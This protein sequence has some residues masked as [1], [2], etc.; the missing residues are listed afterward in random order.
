ML[1]IVADDA[2]PFLRGAFEDYAR[3]EYLPWERIVREKVKDADALII[4]TRTICN[5]GLLEGSSVRFIATATIGYDHI[6]TGYCDEAG[7]HRSS[8]PGCNAGSVMQYMASAIIALCDHTRRLPCEM[9]LGIV[10]VGHVGS[11]VEKLATALGM[12]VLKC[13][14]PRARQEGAGHYLS[15][16]DLL[17][18][19]DIVTLHVPLTMGGADPTC[20]MINEVS[21]KAMKRGAWLIN[22]AR[23]GVAETASLKKAL[24]NGHL[25][26]VILDVWEEEPRID[27]ELLSS[28]LI[29]TP[30]IA[31]YSLDGKA[32]G[33]IMAVRSVAGYFDLPLG[34]WTPRE[35]PADP[36]ELEL[37]PAG[38]TDFT[39]TREAILSVYDIFRDDDRL[40][41]NP[42]MFE[43]QRIHYPLRRDFRA[44][45]IR[46]VQGYHNVYAILKEL[47]FRILPEKTRLP[48]G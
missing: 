8:A 15:F 37:N 38:K 39:A 43:Q 11:R 45:V 19:S 21:I 13:D 47:G 23:G 36:P 6:D 20:H 34:N 4:R 1:R 29:G 46:Q 30:H 7:I 26:G 35:F 12:T 25:S 14:P 17:R 16:D 44:Y 5:R 22:T 48:A 27:R 18:Q 10:G 42:S 24:R 41:S 28:A 31:G 3:V 40:K 32:N 33:T 9:V 2:I